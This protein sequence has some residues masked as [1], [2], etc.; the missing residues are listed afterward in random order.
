MKLSQVVPSLE[1]RYG[2]PSKSVQATARALASAGQEVELLSTVEGPAG[3]AVENSVS[4]RTFHRTWPGCLCPSPGLRAHLLR[5]ESDI[6]HHHSIW[7]R[8]LHYA[9]RASRVRGARFVVSP[10]GMMSH[11]AWKH[12][13]WRKR[14]ARAFV[15]PGALQAVHGWHATSESEAADI[16]LLGFR[17]P[18]CVAP[19]GVTAPDPAETAEAVSYWEQACPEVIQRPVALFYSRYH[20][21]KRVIEL[22]DAWLEHGPRDWLLL[23]V[24]IPQEYT[25]EML[26]SYVMRASAAGPVRIFDGVGAPPPYAIASLFLL[27]SHNENFGLAV[28][29]ALANGIPALVTNTTPW[30]GLNANGGWCVPWESYPATLREATSESAERLRQRGEA[31]RAW[32]LREYSWDR[33][34]GELASFYAR[35]KENLP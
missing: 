6:V 28:S 20:R 30:E 27:P 8:T 23:L 14:L 34:A 31:A 32:V 35:L 33:T 24:G 5:S 3:A 25:V 9:H 11:W 13:A 17:Q 19:N 21:K 16:R 22:I 7:L 2:G 4:M 12:H 26:E 18:I 15:H 10:R 1:E 29:E